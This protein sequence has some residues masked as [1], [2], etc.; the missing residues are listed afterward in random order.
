MLHVDLEVLENSALLG[1][2][3]DHGRRLLVTPLTWQ[4]DV[5]VGGYLVT[6]I[7]L[8][9]SF[10]PSSFVGFSGCAEYGKINGSRETVCWPDR[11][12]LAECSAV[13]SWIIYIDQ[14]IKAVRSVALLITRVPSELISYNSVKLFSIHC[15]YYDNIHS[16]EISLPLTAF[17]NRVIKNTELR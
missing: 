14:T 16:D 9:G 2:V 15:I 12:L 17:Q 13:N 5:R 4:R 1:V 3:T 6:P 11:S 10:Q 7:N 8:S